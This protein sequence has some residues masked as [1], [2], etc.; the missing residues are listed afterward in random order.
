MF[1]LLLSAVSTLPTAVQISVVIAVQI[2][3][4]PSN[5][6]WTQHS[7]NWAYSTRRVQRCACLYICL[8][9]GTLAISSA[10]ASTAP[11][12]STQNIVTYIE[13]LSVEQTKELIF[14]L[15]V[16][17]NVLDDIAGSDKS[18]FLKVKFVQAWLDRDTSASWEKLIVI[19]NYVGQTVLAAKIENVLPTKENPTSS[20][21]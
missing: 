1:V 13:R 12:F 4:F 16:P 11:K 19:L 3:V 14:Y 17:E 2:L 18:R 20:K 10:M 9:T 7:V 5:M 21:G 6:S 15:G 8:C